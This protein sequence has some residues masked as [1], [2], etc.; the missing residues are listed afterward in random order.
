MLK[1][2]FIGSAVLLAAVLLSGCYEKSM[3]EDAGLYPSDYSP[4]YTYV[5]KVSENGRRKRVLVPEACLTNDAPSPANSGPGRLQPG[6]ANNYN[7]QRMVERKSDLRRG[8]TLTAAPAAPAARAAQ[9]YLTKKPETIGGGFSESGRF[10]EDPGRNEND[11]E[12]QT[13]A[14]PQTQTK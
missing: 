12:T 11:N 6:C 7:L 14:K 4:D 10:D 8:R 3:V 13:Q 5:T 2:A 1:K 9:D